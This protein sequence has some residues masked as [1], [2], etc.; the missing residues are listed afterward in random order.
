MR[1]KQLRNDLQEAR[2]NIH[3]S[4][5]LWTSP[6]YYAVIAIVAHYINRDGARQTKLLGIR[7]LDGKHSGANIA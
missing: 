7:R 3:L 5:N 2:S 4:F 1:K 6:N